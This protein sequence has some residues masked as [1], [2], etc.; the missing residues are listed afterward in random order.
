MNHT[1]PVSSITQAMKGRELLE[2]HGIDAA[3]EK[4]VDH[5]GHVGCGYRIRPAA[6]FEK[7]RALLEDAGIAQAW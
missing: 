5:R 3:L 6:H 1:I 4:T 7:A 2:R